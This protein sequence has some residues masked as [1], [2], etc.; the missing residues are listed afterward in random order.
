MAN[1]SSQVPPGS[2]IQPIYGRWRVAGAAP[3]AA[4]IGVLTFD[5]GNPELALIEPMPLADDIEPL[6]P[7]RTSFTVVGETDRGPVSLEHAT[8]A[9]LEQLESGVSGATKVRAHGALFAAV[10]DPGSMPV[11]CLR[12]ELGNLVSLRNERGI[13]R[14][15]PSPDEYSLSWER[16]NPLSAHLDGAV[17]RVRVGLSERA[18]PPF[19]QGEFVLGE[20]GT[21]E[22]ELDE[23]QPLSLVMDRWFRPLLDFVSFAAG[24]A[25][26]VD[27]VAVASPAASTAREWIALK[28]A[29]ITDDASEERHFYQTRFLLPGEDAEFG[30]LLE[31]WI[32][33]HQRLDRA[34]HGFFINEWELGRFMET[35][36]ITAAV[37][38]EGY[39]GRT[40][41]DPNI[42]FRDR[43]AEV[44]ARASRILTTRWK[45]PLADHLGAEFA[46]VARDVRNR[47]VHAKTIGEDIPDG[48]DLRTLA[49]TLHLVMAMC[50][51]EDLGVV[52][53]LGNYNSERQANWLAEL[54][55]QLAHEWTTSRSGSVTQPEDC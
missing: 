55:Q 49:D 45:S 52:D 15:I 44:S 47:L 22:V 16:A 26:S 31:A 33:L 48:A 41:R 10:D 36:F 9:G 23:A 2:P 29:W 24:V 37:A 51:A 14:A 1:K 11:E 8:A 27:H 12:L 40:T 28:R 17:V 30:D 6:G 25:C 54:H 43:I 20:V 3:K 42:G 46:E 32:D 5:R 4:V 39:H 53:R 13:Q 21:I 38:I 50:I 35:R 7:G 18:L 34:L 19:G